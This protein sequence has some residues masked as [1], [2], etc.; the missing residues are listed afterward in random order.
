M[1]SEMLAL[2]PFATPQSASRILPSNRPKPI[3]EEY[4]R[5][6]GG[7]GARRSNPNQTG[8]IKAK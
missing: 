6:H 7:F 5:V 2:I 4:K 8:G 3:G 1:Q